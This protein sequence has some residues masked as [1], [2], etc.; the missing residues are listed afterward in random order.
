MPHALRKHGLNPFV[1]FKST[2]GAEQGSMEA[3]D[4]TAAAGGAAEATQQQ[5]QAEQPSS[6]AA[7]G[8]GNHGNGSKAAH[9]VPMQEQR[10]RELVM[11]T[12][13]GIGL[14]DGVKV[15][16]RAPLGEVIQMDSRSL[17]SSNH[18]VEVLQVTLAAVLMT[19]H[20][21][22]PHG[23]NPPPPWRMT[24][25]VVEKGQALWMK[26][27]VLQAKLL[28]PRPAAKTSFPSMMAVGQCGSISE[29]SS[30]LKLV[31]A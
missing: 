15:N 12:G 1:D 16:G 21:E 20:P 6:T 24:P 23:D 10:G 5:G 11:A 13:P 27:E 22:M 3:S 14:P 7:G 29:G 19:R 2:L 9:G 28:L 4:G 26:M 25:G 8:D 17:D 31:L 18:Q 30:C